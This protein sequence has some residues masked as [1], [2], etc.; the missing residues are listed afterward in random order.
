MSARDISKIDAAT[1]KRLLET[2]LPIAKYFWRRYPHFDQSQLRAA[3]EDA[4]LEAYCTLD[5]T[6]SAEGTWVRLIL[7]QRLQACVRQDAYARH[8]AVSLDKDPQVINGVNPER[9]LEHKRA[10]A[11]INLL[12]PRHQTILMLRMDAY[13]YDQIGEYLGISRPRAGK[14]GS[15]ALAHLRAIL[16]QRKRG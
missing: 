14:E 12:S 15:N 2:Y 10:S 9:A 6:R 4:I 7:R 11:A 8:I 13:T 5:T 3:S 1:A 16:E